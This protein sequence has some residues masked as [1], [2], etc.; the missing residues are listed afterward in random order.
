MASSGLFEDHAIEAHHGRRSLRAGAVV[1][2]A[3]IVITFIQLGTFLVLARLLSPEDY[4]LVGMVT[5]I[6]V[7]APLL[8][9]LG[10]PDAVVRRACITENEIST[11]F[12]FSLGTRVRRRTRHGSQWSSHRTV[13]R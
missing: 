12:W 11:L 2:S 8:V 1:I 5:A 13:L 3:R 4:G 10:T 7:F 9:S 6:T